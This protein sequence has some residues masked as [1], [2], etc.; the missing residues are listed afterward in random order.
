MKLDGYRTKQ[1]LVG[2]SAHCT[3]RIAT[4]RACAA[5]NIYVLQDVLLSWEFAQCALAQSTVR[6]L[7]WN[8]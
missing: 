3:I 7:E 1:S 6:I 8:L 5:H 2:L 4:S